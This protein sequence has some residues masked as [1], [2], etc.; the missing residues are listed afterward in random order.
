MAL[1]GDLTEVPAKDG[2]ESENLDAEEG[3]TENM[4]GTCESRC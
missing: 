4:G 2:E 1:P 3:K